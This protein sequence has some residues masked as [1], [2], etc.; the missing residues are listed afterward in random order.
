MNA[1][2]DGGAASRGSA[3]ND[4]TLGTALALLRLGLGVFLLL[5]SLD[6]MVVP[7]QTSQIFEFWYHVSL[8]VAS[9]P[10]V[11]MLEGTLSLLF[12][13][14][15]ARTW[16]YGAA[17]LVHSVSTVAT[18]PVLLDPFGENHLFIAGI[19]VWFAFLALF[20]LRRRDTRWTLGGPRSGGAQD[21]AIGG[22]G[23]R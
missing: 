7:E 23:N 1:S 21:W 13:A 18:I 3:G 11:G 12:L 5:W 9:A 17:L 14:G 10:L 16:T 2:T 15:V 19:P 20:L 8:P 6:K 22:R 4:R